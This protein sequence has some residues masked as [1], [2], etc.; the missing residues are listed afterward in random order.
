MSDLLARPVL[1]VRDLVHSFGKK[2]VHRNISF[3][4][5]EGEILSIMGASGGGKSL[6]LKSLIG[7]SRPDSGVIQFEGLNLCRLDEQIMQRVRS[8]IGFVFQEGALFD[9]LT[10]EQNLSYPLKLHAR[11]SPGEM[12]DLVNERLALMDLAGSND[13]YPHEI[14]GGM[15]RRVG[16]LR[17][18]MLDPLV[19]LFD[20]PTA[21]LDPIHVAL[22]TRKLIQLKRERG[23]T[24]I[25]VTHDVECAFA[26]SD[27]IAM[28]EQGAI[29]TIGTADE[30]KN[31]PNP[32]VR[33]FLFPDFR[34]GGDERRT[35]S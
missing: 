26:V 14:S 22:F 17:A 6:L 12:H 28:I 27:R 2:V 35:A 13:L 23:I 24:G 10:V 7:L 9:S 1:Q 30:I 18:T 31:S 29:C 11:L 20:E 33:S 5:Y 19:V 4:L 8:K 3:D 16:M 34:G 25:L 32:W 15:Q 21:G